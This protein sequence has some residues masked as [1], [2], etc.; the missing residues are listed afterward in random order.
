MIG[1]LLPPVYN[2]DR[3]V[4]YI[5]VIR[6]VIFAALLQMPPSLAARWFGFFGFSPVI[7]VV[8]SFSRFGSV[9]AFS[10]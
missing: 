4:L 8:S 5:V 6:I 7:G 2:K 9:G 10:C 1:N 3:R